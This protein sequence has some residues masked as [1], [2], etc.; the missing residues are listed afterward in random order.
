MIDCN[1]GLR[2][3]STISLA[4]TGV[5]TFNK[6]DTGD[7]SLSFMD[8]QNKRTTVYTGGRTTTSND[9][10]STGFTLLPC[11]AITDTNVAYRGGNGGFNP[12][13]PF[14]NV[15]LISFE[16]K[17]DD[18]AVTLDWIT[19]TETEA[20]EFLLERSLEG[21][22]YEQF[23]IVAATGN[24]IVNQ[25][26]HLIDNVPVN[27]TKYYRL[28]EVSLNG[29]AEVIGLIDVTVDCNDNFEITNLSP[30]PAVNDVNIVITSG[31]EGPVT[32]EMID[33]LGRTLYSNNEELAVGEN[34]FSLSISGLAVAP[35]FIGVKNVQG[36]TA[37][38]I[39]FVK[40]NE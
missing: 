17:S 23:G 4:L 8:K 7:Y 11:L 29:N 5:Y 24:S 32:I 35:Y 16:G 21:T 40:T 36:E 14:S 3:D 38:Y 37:T 1:T 33:M 34:V 30:N 25:E 2:I 6:V 22:D 19:G 15:E 31:E 18:C 27:G 20:K 12:S 9:I 39:N 13:D 10:D 26:Y 28:I